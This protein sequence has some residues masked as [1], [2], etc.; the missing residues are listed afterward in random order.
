MTH[1]RIKLGRAVTYMNCLASV[2]ALIF[3]SKTLMWNKIMF[4]YQIH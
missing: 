3:L 4:A 1:N 2:V